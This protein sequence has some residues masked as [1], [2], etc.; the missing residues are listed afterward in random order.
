MVAMKLAWPCCFHEHVSLQSVIYGES[1]AFNQVWM[2]DVVGDCAMFGWPI[3]SRH[4]PSTCEVSQWYETT[5]RTKEY[6]EETLRKLDFL[7]Q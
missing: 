5:C 6:T 3:F 2:L 1:I 7:M 4:N